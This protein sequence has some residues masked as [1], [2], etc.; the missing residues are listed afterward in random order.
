M[1][2]FREFL[3][4]NAPAICSAIGVSIT[5]TAILIIWQDKENNKPPSYQEMRKYVISHMSDNEIRRIR[6]ESEKESKTIKERMEKEEADAK[7]RRYKEYYETARLCNDIA[8]KE[9][10]IEKCSEPGPSSLFNGGLEVLVENQPWY[11]E[12]IYEGKI[13]ARCQ[14][15]T[16]RKEAQK[17]GCI[18][19]D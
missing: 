12:N 15:V 2:T 7:D 3:K 18:G 6:N 19:P 8:Y 13:M 16:T 10:H 1:L 9:K 5:F 14:S 17:A 11:V 4:I